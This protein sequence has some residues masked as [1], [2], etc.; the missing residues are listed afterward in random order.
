MSTG[1]GRRALV[2]GASRGIGRAVAVALAA[3]G[4]TVAGS[5]RTVA[6]TAAG[7]VIGVPCDMDDLSAVAALPARAA[8]A[9]GGPVEILVHCAGITRPARVTDIALD[10]W[11]AV[12]RVNVTSALLLAQGCVPAMVGAGSGRVVTIGS[13]YSRMGGRFAGAYAASKHALLGLTRVLAL[14]LATKGV[15]ANVVVPGW[16]DTEMVRAEA[17]SVAR[18]N[19]YGEDEALR[20]FLRGQPLGR[21]V[22]PAE[23]AALVT[24]LCSDQAASITGQAINIDGGSLQS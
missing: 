10:D 13:L 22:T 2:T 21:M 19:G 8:E 6:A 17:R 4:H 16:T 24:F 15:T 7:G 14:E 1:P 9:L 18:A 5:A 11:D 3:A 23:V 20:R 12:M